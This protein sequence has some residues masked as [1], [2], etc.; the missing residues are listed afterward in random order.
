MNHF[1]SN[2]T[3]EKAFKVIVL[4]GTTLITHP[5]LYLIIA[6]LISPSLGGYGRSPSFAGPFLLSSSILC[7]TDVLLYRNMFGKGKVIK[8]VLLYLLVIALAIILGKLD[9]WLF[10]TYYFL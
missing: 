1:K 10:S 5:I 4:Y 2:E 3:M 6:I 9:I 8:S 7:L